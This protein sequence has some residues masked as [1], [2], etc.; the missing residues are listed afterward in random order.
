MM[1]V[2]K[3]AIEGVLL[4]KPRVFGDARG[5]FFET[6]QA[7]RHAAAGVPGPFVQD[8]LSSSAHG[9][10]RGLHVQHPHA[11]GKLVSVIEGEVFDVAVDIRRDSPTFGRHVSAVLSGKNHHQLYVP[12]GFAHGF[13]VTSDHAI[14]AYKCTDF[15]HPECEFSIVW[16]DP[17]IAISW[18]LN[19]PQLSDKDRDAPRLRDVP[20]ERLPR[21][22]ESIR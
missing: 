14:F 2:T 11:Q 20:R 6:W 3:T 13:C 17:D 8:N 4:L 19:D 5:F 7:E 22:Q 16:N 21:Y 18:P 12:P 9:I 10:L 15:Y 1:E